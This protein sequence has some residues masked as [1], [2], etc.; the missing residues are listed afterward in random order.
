MKKWTITAEL[1]MNAQHEETVTVKA[2]T[3]RKACIF[4]KEAFTKKYPSIH[5]MIKIISIEECE[6]T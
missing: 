2:N 3:E 4:A 1:F 6:S 5:N